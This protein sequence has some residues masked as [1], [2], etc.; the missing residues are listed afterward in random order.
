MQHW[1]M[2]EV[3]EDGHY[4]S[5]SHAMLHVLG[6]DC[7]CSDYDEEPEYTWITCKYGNLCTIEPEGWCPECVTY[8]EE[9]Q[10]YIDGYR[11]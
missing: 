1:A 2:S 4:I 5:E 8:F 11:E 9:M 6:A 7:P 3:T 10:E